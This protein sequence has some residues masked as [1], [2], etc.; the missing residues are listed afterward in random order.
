MI[1]RDAAA[2]VARALHR[3]PEVTRVLVAGRDGLPLFDERQLAERDHG[4]A[5]TASA[6]GVAAVVADTLR[7]GEPQGSILVGDEAVAVIR[8]LAAGYALVAVA[9]AGI[10]VGDL[11]RRVRRH[12]RELDQLH[13][14]H[15]A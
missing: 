13:A 2:E 10:D 15:V 9:D 11:H 12:A 3:I 14:E 8:P 5:A 1:L 6:L 7:L 4:A